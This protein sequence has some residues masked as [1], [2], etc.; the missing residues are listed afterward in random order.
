MGSTS[1]WNGLRKHKAML[2]NTNA[3]NAWTDVK[4]LLRRLGQAIGRLTQN[5]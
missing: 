2:M 5:P 4:I 3:H 1:N